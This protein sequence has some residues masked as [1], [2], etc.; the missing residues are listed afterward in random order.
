VQLWQ[1]NGDRVR[2]QGV[3]DMKGGDVIIIEALR[4]CIASARWITPPSRWCSAATR[5]TPAIRLK[6]R[7]PT[8]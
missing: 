3:N 6:S 8:W 7:A 1:R 5:K 4:A 2:G